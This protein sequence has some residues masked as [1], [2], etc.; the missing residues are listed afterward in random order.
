MAV[1]LVG[2]ALGATLVEDAANMDFKIRPVSKVIKLLKDMKAELEADAAN[3]QSVYDK[4]VCW[5]ETNEKDKTSATGTAN[6]QIDGLLSDIERLTAKGAQLKAEIAQAEKEKAANEKA[7][8]DATAVREKESSEFNTDEKDMLQSLQAMKNAVFVLSKHHESFLQLPVTKLQAVQTAAKHALGRASVLLPSQQKALRALVQQPNANAGSYQPAS[9][10]IFGI[11]KQMKEEFESNLST[12]QKTEQ[13]AVSDFKELKKAKEYEIDAAA[14][15]IKQKTQDAADAA[16][17]LAESKEN[18]ESTREALG[19]DKQFLQELKLRCQQTDKDFELRTKARADE[20]A[21]VAEAIAILSDDDNK[22]AVDK[23]AFIQLSSAQRQARNRGA[24]ALMAASKRTGSANLAGLAVRAHAAMD[25]KT[26]A[27]VEKAIDGTVEELKKVQADE[28]V[29][30][31]VCVKDLRENDKAIMIKNREIK[32]YTAFIE[33]AD[34]IVAQLEKEIK[35]HFENTKETEVQMKVASEER[36]AQN[37]EFQTAVSE[38]RAAQDV[39]KKALARLKAF[40]KEKDVQPSLVQEMGFSLIQGKQTPGAAAPPPPPGFEKFEQN[41]G[42]AGVMQLIQNVI[43][44]AET[45]EKD[46]M[47]AETDA[48]AAYVEFITNS[49]AAIKGD[50]DAIAMKTEQKTQ[51]IADKETSEADRDASL[52]DAENLYK[53]KADLHQACDFLIEN[54]DLRQHAR[55]EEMEALEASKQMFHGADV[56]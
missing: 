37:K 18:L 15:Q 39:L 48:Q 22:E 42:A 55:I 35:Q 12:E 5:C 36:E 46:A 53:T 45:M 43:E 23:V 14:S 8:K 44:D 41:K 16:N 4:L 56:F 17:Q 11:L 24:E 51:T 31:D 3:D 26:F 19:A 1:W 27:K 25:P 9:G 50:K 30:K 49:N 10:Q 21:A 52:K 54:F 32:E 33:E 20:I 13:Q 29:Q 47:T 7:L 40:Y 28:V 34:S 6:K 38:Q 2:F